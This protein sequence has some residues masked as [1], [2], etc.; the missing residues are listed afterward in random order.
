VKVLVC[1]SRTYD[2]WHQM[3]SVLWGLKSY[4]IRPQPELTIIEGGARGADTLA[5]NWADQLPDVEHIRVP[6]RWDELG[7]RAGFVRNIEMLD[8]KPD[9]VIAFFDQKPT[10]GTMHT[11]QHAKAR[12]IPVWEIT[13]NR[14]AIV[15]AWPPSSSGATSPGSSAQLSL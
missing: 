14:R 7:K 10:G 6:A 2:D 15:E 8:M 1:G 12:R 9:L 4:L 5:G 3:Y 13:S 11:V